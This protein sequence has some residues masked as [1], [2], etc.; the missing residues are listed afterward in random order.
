[1]AAVAAYVGY[2]ALA[3]QGDARHEDVMRFKETD[4]ETPTPGA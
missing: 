3:P 1:M 2:E 4:G